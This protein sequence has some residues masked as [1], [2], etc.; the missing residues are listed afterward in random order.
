MKKLLV[1]ILLAFVFNYFS[2]VAEADTLK[3]GGPVKI[4]K[5][6]RGHRRHWHRHHRHH[7]RHRKVVIIRR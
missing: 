5:K 7:W 1:L 4:H 2:P 3:A 6:H